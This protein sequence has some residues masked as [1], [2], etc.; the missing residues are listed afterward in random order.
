MKIL[1]ITTLDVAGRQN[2]R[3]HHL[4]AHYMPRCSDFRVIYRSRRAADAPLS[5]LLAAEARMAPIQGVRHVAVT[6]RLSPPDGLVRETAAGI[7]GRSALRRAAGTVMDGLG[8][9]RDRFT[10]SALRQAA[11]QECGPDTLV[12]ALGPWAALAAIPLRDAG[13]LTH[14]VY[15]DRDYEPGFT[16]SA[17]RR[18]IAVR[19]ER[20]AAAHADL[21]LSIGHRL[22]ARFADVP[23]ARTVLSPTGVDTARFPAPRVPAMHPPRLIHV[24]EVAPWAGLEEAIDALPALTGV[25][26]TAIGPVSDGYRAALVARAEARGLAG[27]VEITGRQPRDAVIAEL[28]RGGI[29][30][31]VFRPHPLRQYAAPLKVLEYMA[32]GLPVLAAEGSEA[33]D[34]VVRTQTGHAL[35]CEASAIAEA[36]VRFLGDP[37]RYAA[38]AAAGPSVARAHDWTT[39]LTR[40]YALLQDLVANK[41]AA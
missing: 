30:Y 21:T 4:I 20:Q 1:L 13:L 16:A 33:G 36:A 22:M 19:A 17:L 9:L 14:V 8:V 28:S 39:I 25:G 15:V 12:L 27:R 32:A 40:E 11:R 24:G 37:G 35:P 7:R 31:A 3:E 18:A 41:A 6:P 34:M 38:L 2:N 5:S 29:G 26:L 10:I 23:G